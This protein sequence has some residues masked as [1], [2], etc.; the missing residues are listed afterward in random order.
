MV[1]LLILQYSLL[2]GEGD[3]DY[4]KFIRIYPKDK[5]WYIVQ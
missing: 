4:Y 1:Q 3:P 2:E 5:H